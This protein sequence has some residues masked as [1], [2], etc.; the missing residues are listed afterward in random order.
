MCNRVLKIIGMAAL[1]VVVT[2]PL[3]LAQAKG[4]ADPTSFSGHGHA[5]DSLHVKNAWGGSVIQCSSPISTS[6]NPTTGDVSHSCRGPD[7][8]IYTGTPVPPSGG[9]S[10][11]GG[12]RPKP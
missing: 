10:T 7:G 9:G 3:S 1:A 4:K 6:T 8:S 11:G 5:F 12:T 2:A